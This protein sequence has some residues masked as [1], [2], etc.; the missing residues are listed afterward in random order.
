MYMPLLYCNSND[1][2][3]KKKSFDS[4]SLRC[5]PSV[6]RN[7]YIK[8][9]NTY[10][11]NLILCFHHSLLAAAAYQ[12]NEFSGQL[13]DFHISNGIRAKVSRKPPPKGEERNADGGGSG[14]GIY[15]TVYIYR[16]GVERDLGEG[17]RTYL[18]GWLNVTRVW[19]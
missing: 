16:D 9:K 11:Y 5:R 15:I 4:Y 19:K 17:K 3:Q 18:Y 1:T 10:I 7:L 12:E 2:R 13:N 8:K 14:C 6:H